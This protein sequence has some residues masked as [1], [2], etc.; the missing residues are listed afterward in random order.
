MTASQRG[1]RLGFDIGGT[2]TDFAL[3]H[4]E[5]GELKVWKELTTSHDPAQGVLSGLRGL[6]ESTGVRASQVETAIHGTTLVANTLIE[7]TGAKVALLATKG[8]RDVLEIRNEQRYDIYDLFLQFPQP[9]VPRHLRFP[10]TER[11]DRDG[12]TLIKPEE[13]ELCG[14]AERLRAGEVQAVAI[15]F[16][17]SFRNAQNEE[18][19]ARV[20]ENTLP[21]IPVSLS[22]QVGPEVRE[23]E[24]TSTTVANAYV[25]PR[26]RAYL[27]RLE[28]LLQ[29]Q[30]YGG[31][32]YLMLSSGG[33]TSTRTASD[34]P[35]RLVESGPAAGAIAASHFGS[36][37]NH[38]NVISFDMGGTTAKLCL[39]Q[40]GQP[41]LARGLEVARVSRFRKGSGLPLQFPS[42]D[43]IEIG[44]GGG[45]I[46]QV[47]RLGL[48]KVGPS[49]AG[50]N[51][52]PACYGLGGEEPTV[53]D[54]NLL[55]GYLNPDYFLG[56]RMN[57]DVGAAGRALET[58]GKRLN[59]SPVETAW[60]IHSLVN[61]NMAAAARIHVIEQGQD[62]RKFPLLA[63]GGGGP[64]HAAGVARILNSPEVI[65]PPSAGVASAVG[66]LIAPLSFEL[67]QS[68]PTRWEDVDPAQI[69]QILSEMQRKGEALLAEAGTRDDTRV[70]RSADGRFVGQLHELTV[71]L[72]REPLRR[73]HVES[74]RDRFMRLYAQRYGHLPQ[75]RSLEFLS[76]RV[77]VS[78]P[79][80][81]RPPSPAPRV[82]D[83]GQALRGKR[84]AYVGKA[85]FMETPVYDRYNMTPGMRL[86]GPAILEEREST[87]V[88][89]PDMTLRVDGQLN[90]IMGKV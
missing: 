6:Y 90:L 62:P 24:R 32:L 48:L 85:G 66:L 64:I 45:S 88:V 28:G 72:P 25:Q 4:P 59:L 13:S 31:R 56:G 43:M 39:I 38:P 63:Y 21:G 60:G 22:S 44:A 57:L 47:D 89:P 70:A 86:D 54:A 20:M 81:L 78:G 5:T 87:A 34:F 7:R 3:L 82:R 77:T 27:N 79:R 65:C 18:W 8:F 46:A 73:E 51:P 42:I 69:E 61:E 33:T 11:V 29:E 26:L 10:V 49:S 36:A 80:P 23:Y 2:F 17:H 41:A 37:A 15:S 30:G 9:L 14:I 52:G 19:V 67:V 75:A 68:V 83:P 1:Y 74:V 55:L 58:L 53:T 84:R 35:I 76:W 40:N 12:N 16:L 50:A 71:P